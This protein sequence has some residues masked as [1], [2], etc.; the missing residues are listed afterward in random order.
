MASLPCRPVCRA[1]QEPPMGSNNTST[2]SRS[3]IR[4]G[5]A[6]S[7]PAAK[8]PPPQKGGS[9]AF[10]VKVQELYSWEAKIRRNMLVE[11]AS[12]PRGPRPSA[13]TAQDRT[14]QHRTGQHRTGQDRTGQGR[15]GQDRTGLLRRR[16]GV[17][18]GGGRETLLAHTWRIPLF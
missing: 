13:G 2:D 16:F 14:G 10:S 8:S 3:L 5:I 18:A 6:D 17:P 11:A 1:P 9:R 15:A 4:M 7:P 12:T